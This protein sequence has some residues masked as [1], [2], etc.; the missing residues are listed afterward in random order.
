MIYKGF[1]KLKRL[2]LDLD[3]TVSIT[4]NGQYH[5]ST[6]ILSMVGAIRRY[7]E[8]GFE[9]VFSTSRN[10][11]TYEGNVGKINANTLPIIIEWLKT[12]NIPYDEIY[13]GKPWCGF[14]GFYVDDKAIR[15]AE[16]VNLS[17]EEIRSLLEKDKLDK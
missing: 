17:Y 12:H 2:I 5:I 7:R 6:P 11:R 14:E 13:V 3:E 16:F 10:M 4:E 15:P 9:I 8:E 1:W